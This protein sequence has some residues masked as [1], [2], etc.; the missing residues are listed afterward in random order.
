M[1]RILLIAW[2]NAI[3]IFIPHNLLLILIA[4][5]KTF[6]YAIKTT[7]THLYLLLIIDLIAILLFGR[8][9]AKALSLAA[10][11]GTQTYSSLVALIY[12]VIEINWFIFSSAA[13]LFI[14]QKNKTEHW[15]KYFKR[16]FFRYIQLTL[17]FSLVIFFGISFLMWGGITKLPSIHWTIASITHIFELIAIFYW[18]ESLGR[19]TDLFRSIEKSANFIFYNLPIIL[20]LFLILISFNFINKLIFPTYVTN[21]FGASLQNIEQLRHNISI[22]SLIRFILFRYIKF[23]LEYIWIALFFVIYEQKKHA[24][25][26]TTYFE[27]P[28]E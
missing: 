17:F 4:T 7:F 16:S 6:W 13:L 2:F 22:L 12:L 20:F 15:A 19:L 1:L 23:I 9:I 10:Q 25:Y 11:K 21:I 5:I 14:Q 24:L 3:K 8:P 18:I 26:G 28:N 27:E